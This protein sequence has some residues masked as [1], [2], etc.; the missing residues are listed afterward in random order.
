MIKG[1]FILYQIEI[2][3]RYINLQGDHLVYLVNN[4]KYIIAKLIKDQAS[5]LMAALVNLHF[6]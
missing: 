5:A 3:A 4:N 6:T 1:L 2:T